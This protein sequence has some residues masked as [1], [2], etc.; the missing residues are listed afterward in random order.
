[1]ENGYMGPFLGRGPDSAS[2]PRKDGKRKW[3]WHGHLW[4][5]INSNLTKIIFEGWNIDLETTKH[6]KLTIN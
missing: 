3:R 6:E 2:G 5:S 4:G 1:M